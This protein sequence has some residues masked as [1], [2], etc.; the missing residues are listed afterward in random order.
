MTATN[1]ILEAIATKNAEGHRLSNTDLGKIIEATSKLADD[2]ITFN[3]FKQLHLQITKDQNALIKALTKREL[4]IL[5]LIGLQKNSVSISEELKIKL[6][7]VETHRK[8]MR[9][10]LKVQGNGKLYQYAIMAN[11]IKT[12]TFI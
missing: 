11:I 1:Y 3:I 6:S 2:S 4:E 7:T 12:Q 5:Q 9:R 8:N 10:K